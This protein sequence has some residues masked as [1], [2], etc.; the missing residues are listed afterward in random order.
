MFYIDI[1]IIA[2]SYL[3]FQSL[4]K[5]VY[6]YV[7]MAVVTFTVDF[8][9]EGSKQ[10]VQFLIISNKKKEIAE[11]INSEVSRGI[12]VLKGQGWYS[13]TDVDPLLVLARRTQFKQI[14]SII[15]N[16]DDNAFV[17]VSKV[18]GVYGMGFDKIRL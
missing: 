14:M 3:I 11:R 4:E 7:T 18:M 13:G 1:F 10:S 5:M 8:A 15:K 16:T 17:S 9:L 2:S 12:T 6:G